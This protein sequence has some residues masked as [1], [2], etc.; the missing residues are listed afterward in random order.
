[1]FVLDRAGITGDDG[2]THHGM[3]D[4][5]YLRVI[6]GMTVSAPSDPAE[7]RR[8]LATGLQHNGPFTLRYPR[9]A[10]PACDPSVMEPVEVGRMRV[11]REGGDVALVAVGKMVGLASQAAERLAAAGVRATVV[12]ARFVKP[13]DPE[14]APLAARHRAV[15]TVEDGTVRGGFGSG[16]LELL[17]S[18]DVQVPVRVLG[19][20]DGF[21]EHGAQ[22]TLLG[23]FGLDADG[24]AAAARALLGSLPESALA[25]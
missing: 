8:L 6:P 15:V 18:A 14:L 11:L 20:P 22:A 9:G 1:V 10:A 3:L 12:D 21:I 2:P 24:I 7:L 17:A 23:S 13:V 19:L 25:G 16:V 5:A 4:L